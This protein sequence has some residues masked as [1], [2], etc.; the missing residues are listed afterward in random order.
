MQR[1]G[2]QLRRPEQIRHFPRRRFP[3]A[4]GLTERV[5][6]GVTS[7][8]TVAQGNEAPSGARGRSRIHARARAADERPL[9]GPV[10]ER[11]EAR[12]VRSAV[13]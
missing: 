2:R 12:R 13:H 8:L 7:L 9:R 6:P 5:Q 11:R 3:E 4:V 1:L 10:A